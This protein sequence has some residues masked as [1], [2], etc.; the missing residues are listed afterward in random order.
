VL[1]FAPT[2]L[3]FHTPEKTWTVPEGPIRSAVF[4]V[5]DAV[6]RTVLVLDVANAPV[7]PSCKTPCVTCSEVPLRLPEIATAFPG[8]GLKITLPAA[9]LLPAVV[10]LL[11][12]TIDPVNTKVPPAPAPTVCDAAH[13]T[14]PATTCVPVTNP[15]AEIPEAPTD[16]IAPP[17]PPPKVQ[18]PVDPLKINPDTLR[19]TLITGWFA[20]G[21][22]GIT[23]M[24][25]VKS[26]AGNA[27]QFDGFSKSRFAAPVHVTLAASARSPH[28]MHPARIDNAHPAIFNKRRCRGI[29]GSNGGSLRPQVGNSGHSYLTRKRSAVKL[30]LRKNSEK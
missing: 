30:P 11:P 7:P 8:P 22:P 19:L 13:A 23:A 1:L 20:T 5:A 9:E 3:R 12:D 6:L 2:S 16:K 28:P 18:P 15:A 14:C 27:D 25:E 10:A 4:P 26:F 17:V 24:S 21:T 29:P